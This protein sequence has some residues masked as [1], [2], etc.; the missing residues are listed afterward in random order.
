MGVKTCSRNGCEEIMCH[1]Y[2]NEIGYVCNDCRQ[3]FIDNSGGESIAQNIKI[4]I[5]SIKEA[6]VKFLETKKDKSIGLS[7]TLS[8]Y[9]KMHEDD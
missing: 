5:K 1:T 8:E 9:F 2:I 6:L 7:V 4:N 3:E